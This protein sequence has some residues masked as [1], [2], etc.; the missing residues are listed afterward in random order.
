MANFSIHRKNTQG[1]YLTLLALLIGILIIGFMFTSKISTSS[2][3]STVD[4]N[5]VATTTTQRTTQT[6]IESQFDAINAARDVKS[7]LEQKSRDA[8]EQQ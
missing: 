7:M 1:G 2:K 5:G 6:K 4:E 3:T 8:A